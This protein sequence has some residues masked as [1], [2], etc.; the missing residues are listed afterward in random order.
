MR[1]RLSISSSAVVAVVVDGGDDLVTGSS[2]YR[3]ANGG[4]NEG[5]AVQRWEAVIWRIISSVARRNLRR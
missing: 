5:D 4:L 3:A 1:T 2:A